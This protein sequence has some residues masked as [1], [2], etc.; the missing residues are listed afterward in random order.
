MA[1]VDDV[2]KSQLIILLDI[3]KLFFN[4]KL[5]KWEIFGHR[6][7]KCLVSFLKNRKCH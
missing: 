1:I 4:L 6:H 3:I 7:L 5:S 2:E